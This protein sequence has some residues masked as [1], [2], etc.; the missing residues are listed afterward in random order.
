MR[1]KFQGKEEEV[2]D[3]STRKQFPQSGFINSFEGS[4]LLPYKKIKQLLQEGSDHKN[5]VFLLKTKFYQKSEE[6]EKTTEIS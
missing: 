6:R 2:F 3:D 4:L 1:K 5:S